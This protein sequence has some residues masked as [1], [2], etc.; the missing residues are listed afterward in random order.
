MG[1]W[2]IRTYNAEVLNSF[3]LMCSRQKVRE[4]SLNLKE[5]HTTELVDLSITK[6]G[7]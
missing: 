4:I 1:Q 2:Q 6:E 5:G 7:I 3:L